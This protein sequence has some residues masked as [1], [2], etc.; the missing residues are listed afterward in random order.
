MIHSLPT[1]LISTRQHNSAYVVGQERPGGVQPQWEAEGAALGCYNLALPS[2]PERTRKKV[3][4]KGFNIPYFKKSNKSYFPLSLFRN[5]LCFIYKL[6]YP[7]FFSRLSHSPHF[8]RFSH[9][10]GFVVSLFLD[11]RKKKR[12]RL[13]L[14]IFIFFLDKYYFFRAHCKYNRPKA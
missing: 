13:L 1:P 8:L 11:E 14:F 3:Q 6:N 4:K 7:L 9:S 10:Q 2:F 5:S 12:K